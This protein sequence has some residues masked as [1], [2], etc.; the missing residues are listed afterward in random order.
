[1]PYA[2]PTSL[3]C[4]PE[5]GAIAGPDAPLTGLTEALASGEA[6][7]G[8]SPVT[9]ASVTHTNSLLRVRS[10]L[11]TMCGR[12]P[13]VRSEPAGIVHAAS[14]LTFADLTVGKAG[15]LVGCGKA[16]AGRLAPGAPVDIITGTCLFGADA[17]T[18]QAA[19]RAFPLTDPATV[20]GYAGLPFDRIIADERPHLYELETATRLTSFIRD[21]AGELAPSPIR[22]RAHVPGPEYELYGISL[23]A[24]GYFTRAQCERYRDAV[25]HRTGTVTRMLEAALAGVAEVT[26]SSPL[27]W[28]SQINLY[29]VPRGRIPQLLADAT[30][31]QDHLWGVLAGVLPGPPFLV[32]RHASYLHHYLAAAAESAQTGSQLAA[33]E[34]P[35][36]EAI[37]RRAA[38]LRARTGISLRDCS[39]LYVHPRVVVR[40]TAFGLAPRLLY[41]CQDGCNPRWASPAQPAWPPTLTGVIPGPRGCLR[42]VRSVRR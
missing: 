10:R 29:G 15:Y 38:A 23:H 32:L 34:N 42:S 11:D 3:D 33:V 7:F 17:L 37:Y 4:A 6:R 18:G 36:E 22:V 26:A 39:G 27:D 13:G 8:T 19:D 40:R 31:K 21:L 14:G 2:F 5:R 12:L 30:A 1:M 20:S 16:Y 35:D 24:R 28:I 25:R 41:N 9:A